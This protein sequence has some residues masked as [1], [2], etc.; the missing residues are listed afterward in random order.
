MTVI[1]ITNNKGGVGKTTTAVN[2]AVA[3][4]RLDRTV[5][6]IDLDPQGSLAVWFGVTPETTLSDILLAPGG[7][8]K[9]TLRDAVISLDRDDF[10]RPNLALVASTR[11]LEETTEELLLQD[12]VGARKLGSSRMHA[13]LSDR[14][15]PYARVYDYVI[16]D[17]PPKLDTL[18]AATYSFA[19]FAIVPTRPQSIS[20]SGT[21]EHT[22]ELDAYRKIGVK[23][24]LMYLLPTMV[25]FRQNM[26]RQMLLA[27]RSTYG[28]NMIPTAIPYATAVAE[29]PGSGGL[30]ILE[31]GPDH[32]AAQAY[33]TLAEKV[34]ER[35]KVWLINPNAPIH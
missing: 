4:S 17:C 12:F 16:L 1:A 3:L 30:A 14:L 11:K 21:V 9:Q 26:D 28:Q 5:L 35:N 33:M 18:K 24:R 25:Q 2:L 13:I 22:E 10:S 19:D 20:V 29:S 27:L 31:Y 23:M 32:P 6:L 7:Y 8:L 15:E 34:E